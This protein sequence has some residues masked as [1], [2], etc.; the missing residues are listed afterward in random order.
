MKKLFGASLIFVVFSAPLQFGLAIAFDF[1]HDNLKHVFKS[2]TPHSSVSAAIPSARKVT[3][4]ATIVRKPVYIRADFIFVLNIL[5]ILF[6][7]FSGFFQVFYGQPFL[8]PEIFRSHHLRA[9][10]AVN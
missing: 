1:N 7:V 4:S 2:E 6:L 5:A 10:P 9:P 8:F 3:P